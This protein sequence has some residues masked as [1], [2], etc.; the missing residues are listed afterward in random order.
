MS[1]PLI[2]RIKEFRKEYIGEFDSSP[3]D[4]RV[5]FDEEESAHKWDGRLKSALLRI[6]ALQSEVRYC[7]ND[8]LFY[9]NLLENLSRNNDCMVVVKT[10]PDMDAWCVS[11]T[12]G[13][14]SKHFSS[15]DNDEMIY[16]FQ[17]HR[18]AALFKLFWYEK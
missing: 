6:H 2:D 3:V 4:Q 12:T 1:T 16:V 13:K 17:H 8:V 14:W 9:R 10:N 18:D 5:P 11:N 7:R 15:P